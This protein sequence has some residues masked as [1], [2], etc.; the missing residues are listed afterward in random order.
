MKI[1]RTKS[2]FAALLKVF[3]AFVALVMLGLTLISL[4]K[5]V[6]AAPPFLPGLVFS[7]AVLLAALVTRPTHANGLCLPLSRKGCVGLTLFVLWACLWNAWNNDFTVGDVNLQSAFLVSL[8]TGFWEELFFRGFVL[9]LLSPCGALGAVLVSSLFFAM[10]HLRF[11]GNALTF[12]SNMVPAFS[13]GLLF[14]VS[15]LQTNSIFPAVIAHATINFVSSLFSGLP[16][17]GSY[18]SMGLLKFSSYLVFA[19]P[20]L[21]YC[22]DAVRKNLKDWNSHF[23]LYSHGNIAT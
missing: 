3:M 20:I 15:R 17:N 18:A 8:L 4:L 6:I 2:I 16:E 1:A 11:G 13:L 14:A 7:V 5:Q 19:M 22:Y 23:E 12:V 9:R 10:L 21:V